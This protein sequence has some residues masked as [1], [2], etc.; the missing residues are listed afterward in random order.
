MPNS[1]NGDLEESILNNQ[2]GYICKNK[3]ELYFI[4]QQEYSKFIN[5]EEIRICRD[6]AFLKQI[7]RNAAADKLMSLLYGENSLNSSLDKELEII[8][9]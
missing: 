7:S 8:S 6:E 5:K 9:R 3:E 2:A 1:D 4:L